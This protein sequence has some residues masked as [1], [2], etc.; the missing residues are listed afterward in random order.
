MN[1]LLCIMMPGF[2]VATE[3]ILGGTPW[4]AIPVSLCNR[5][6]NPNLKLKP[7]GLEDKRAANTGRLPAPEGADST[8]NK[9]NFTCD[10]KKG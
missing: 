4:A 1:F 9:E 6:Q 2:S 5:S 7:S 8:E 3:G 10:V